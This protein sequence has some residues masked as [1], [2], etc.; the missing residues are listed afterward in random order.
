MGKGRKLQEE[1]GSDAP[2]WLNILKSYSSNGSNW[3]DM[4][5]LHF[6][7][8]IL[9][10]EFLQLLKSNLSSGNNV[11]QIF[12]VLKANRG[13]YEVLDVA[14]KE[15]NDGRGL[16]KTMVALGWANFRDRLASLYVYKAIHNKFPLKTDMGLVEDIQKFESTYSDIALSGTSRTFLLGLYLKLAQIRTQEMERNKFIEFR[17]P[18]ELITP[19][20]KL[21]QVRSEKPDWL[22][23][24]TFHFC[25]ALGG[26][27]LAGA[28]VSGKSF[29]EIYEMLNDE[30]R[31]LLHDNLLTYGMSIQEPETFLYEKI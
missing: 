14:F 10:K 23:L 21:S 24:Q 28:L 1:L 25:E 26:K 19:I 22:I 15:F 3:S 2:P 6:P 29:D 11:E 31:K 18:E 9:P 20:L 27:T 16:E 12:A 30:T 5:K 7:H 4:K 8:I 13:L 17:L